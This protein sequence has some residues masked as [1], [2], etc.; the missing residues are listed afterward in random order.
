MSITFV[1]LYKIVHIFAF[2][3]QTTQEMFVREVS[4]KGRV[5]ITILHAELPI[6][7]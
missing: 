5:I 1:I 7:Y 6:F 4:D 3:T 2:D